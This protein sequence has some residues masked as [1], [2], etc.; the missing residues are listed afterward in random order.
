MVRLL[1]LKR[2][3]RVQISMLLT[4]SDQVINSPRT[5]ASS[6]SGLAPCAP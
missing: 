3:A 1:A 5:A 2:M 6:F 4:C